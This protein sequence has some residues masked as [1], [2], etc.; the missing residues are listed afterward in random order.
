LRAWTAGASSPLN[1][2]VAEAFAVARGWSHGPNSSPVK[3]RGGGT[4]TRRELDVLRLIADGRADREIAE[5]LF[6]SPRTVMA[7]VRHIFDKLGVHS[8]KAAVVAAR[9]HGFV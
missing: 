2:I 6:I 3:G 9:E 8:R 7:H 4:L 1:E 5:A